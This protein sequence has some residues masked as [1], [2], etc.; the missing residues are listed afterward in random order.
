MA[1]I[2]KGKPLPGH[3]RLNYDEC[4][5]KLVLEKFFPEKY[6]SLKI[7]DRPDLRDDMHNIGI[8]VTSAIPR[9]EQEALSLSSKIPFL[10]EKV[11]ERRIEYLNKKGYR[12]TKYGMTHPGYGYSWTGCEIPPIEKT[13]CAEFLNAVLKK[14]DK[15]NSGNYESLSQYDLFVQSEL[16]VEDWMGSKILERLISIFNGEKKYSTIYLLGV[17]G[18]FVFDVEKKT[19]EKLETDIKLY[20]LGLQARAM[21]EEGEKE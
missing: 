3:T 20:G 19:W 15:L 17:N 6:N 2:E 1:K 4:Y 7:S 14:I 11:Q 16:L 18:L 8:E 12:Y 10:P 13:C 21:V 9:Q 5:A